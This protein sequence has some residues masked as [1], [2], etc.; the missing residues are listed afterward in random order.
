MAYLDL[1]RA[2]FIPA[3]ILIF[4]AGYITAVRV[5][6]GF[7]LS[8][9][10]RVILIAVFG[11]EAG[12]VLNDYVDR[13]LDK[14]D[15]DN[16][17]TK[18]FRPFK[19]RP[20]AGGGLK[21]RVALITF[22]LFVTITIILIFTIPSPHK[23]YVLF[24]MIYAYIVEY[25]YQIKKRHQTF[26][27]AQLI[28]RTDFAFFPIA[29]YLVLAH[30]DKNAFLYFLY[31]YPLAQ[32]HL[33]IND[34]ADYKN[35]LA[36]KLFSVPKLCGINGTLIWVFAFTFVHLITA[37]YFV[38][39]VNPKAAIGFILSFTLIIFASVYIFK[40]KTPLSALRVL[41]LIHLSM[42]LQSL[43]LIFLH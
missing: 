20:L 6:G 28:G 17:L 41:P 22:F 1:L 7:D 12:M 23:Y 40:K 2:H 9:L 37:T 36:R 30:P 4:T 42:A 34:L 43:S 8:I 24:L 27:W 21:A 11:F 3:W 14:K 29:G 32:A 18:Y 10:I 26:P 38:L 15:I 33:A 35:D 13:D 5:Y 39:S 19:T 16:S 31:F 25:F